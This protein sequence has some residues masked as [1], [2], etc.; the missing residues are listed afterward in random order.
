MFAIQNLQTSFIPKRPQ[1]STES[2]IRIVSR[3]A[4]SKEDN[5]YPEV[6]LQ[7]DEAGGHFRDRR[8]ESLASCSAETKK[9]Q[10]LRQNVQKIVLQ[11][12]YV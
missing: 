2:P 12:T 10:V 11:L 4:S 9:N 8:F 1:L 7:P 3:K 5:S 6:C